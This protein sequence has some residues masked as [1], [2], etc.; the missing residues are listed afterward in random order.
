M[1][2]DFN[3]L[4]DLVKDYLAYHGLSHTLETFKAEE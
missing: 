4:N 3:Q 1:Q 2:V